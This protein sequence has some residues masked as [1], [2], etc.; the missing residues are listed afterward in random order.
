MSYG[1]DVVT[2]YRLAAFYVGRILKGE[3]PAELPVQY[4]TKY[5][6]VINLKTARALGLDIPPTHQTSQGPNHSFRRAMSQRCERRT[7]PLRVAERNL[8]GRSKP[9]SR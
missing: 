6:L 7:I 1:N 3:K 2:D 4:P 8:E 5:E 9:P